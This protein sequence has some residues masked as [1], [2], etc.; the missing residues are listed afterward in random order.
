MANELISRGYEIDV[1]LVLAEGELLKNLDNRVNIIDFQEQRIRG[2][3]PKLVKYLKKTKPSALI[4][5]MWPLNS[6]ALAANYL[7]FGMRKTQIILTEHCSWSTV[8]RKS[9]FAEVLM[10]K[11]ICFSYPFASKV[12]AVSDGAKQDFINFTGLKFINNLQTIYNPVLNFDN[13]VI[14]SHKLCEDW[15]QGSHHKIL[16]VGNLKAIKDYVTLLKAFKIVSYVNDAKLLVLGEGEMRQTLTKLVADLGLADRC[17]LIGQVKNPN[18]YYQCAD[19]FVLSSIGEGLPT[20]IIEALAF[21]VP[22]VS[23]DCPNG[24]AEI[25]K[26]GKYGKF[27]GVGDVEQLAYAMINSLGQKPDKIFLKSRAKDFEI[28]KSVDAYVELLEKS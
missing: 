9:F 18:F 19:L 8:P 21:G 16:A 6:L 2:S 1:L 15:Y 27:V 5:F 25:L 3:F 12:I 11:I 22:V 13:L 14:D 26:N 17:N 7:A 24:P 20:V 28:A 23:T 4:A 10:K